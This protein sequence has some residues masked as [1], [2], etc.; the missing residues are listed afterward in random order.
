MSEEKFPI[1][2]GPDA[3]RRLYS[4]AIDLDREV[5]RL[6]AE[7]A[8]LLEAA[9]AVIDGA[10]W[11]ARDTP[12]AGNAVVSNLAVLRAAVEKAEGGE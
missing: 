6:M 3:H 9:R 12:M 11:Y 8:E 1:G 7:R 4:L 2:L 5:T 10:C